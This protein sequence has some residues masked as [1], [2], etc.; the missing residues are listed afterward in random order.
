MVRYY[1]I[2][3]ALEADAALAAGSDLA[4]GRQSFAD[5]PAGTDSRP[6]ALPIKKALTRVK[7]FFG[8]RVELLRAGSAGS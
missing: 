5:T 3:I 1:R 4:V 6:T 2:V 7:A 8:V